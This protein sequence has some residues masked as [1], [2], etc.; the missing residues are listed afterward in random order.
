MQVFIHVYQ[1]VLNLFIYIY[2]FRIF[3]LGHKINMI[4]EPL[5]RQGFRDGDMPSESVK[6]I[7][8]VFLV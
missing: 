4:F 3:S 8:S 6:V 2:S 1:I 7:P 5:P